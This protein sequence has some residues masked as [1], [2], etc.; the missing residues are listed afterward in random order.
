[1]SFKQ[2]F[3]ESWKRE[4][5]TGTHHKKIEPINNYLTRHEKELLR[6][7][8]HTLKVGDLVDVIDRSGWL[9]GVMAE[10]QPIKD[11]E[12]IQANPDMFKNYEMEDLFATVGG[13]GTNAS[14]LYPVGYMPGDMFK[15]TLNP[16]TVRE[17]GGLIDEL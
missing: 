17:L 11:I 1:M 2:Y 13:V 15:K 5:Y 3:T 9:N 8:R 16:D 7:W 12:R 6:Q 4:A 10:N 14:C